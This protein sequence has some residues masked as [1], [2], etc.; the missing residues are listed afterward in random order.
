MNVKSI[1]T[2]SKRAVLLLIMGIAGTMLPVECDKILHGTK[3]ESFVQRASCARQAVLAGD[4]QRAYELMAPVYNHAIGHKKSSG[5]D[6]RAKLNDIIQ[7]KLKGNKSALVEEYG[8]EDVYAAMA[9][10]ADVDPATGRQVAIQEKNRLPQELVQQVQTALQAE[11]VTLPAIRK[12]VQPKRPKAV[13]PAVKTFSP[14]QQRAEIERSRAE[15]ESVEEEVRPVEPIVPAQ[16]PEIERA[17][18]ITQPVVAEPVIEEPVIPQAPPISEYEEERVMYRKPSKPAST[19]GLIPEARE[20]VL[21]SGIMRQPQPVRPTVLSPEPVPE[22][23]K[24]IRTIERES[25]AIKPVIEE[26]PVIPEAPPISAQEEERVMYRKPSKPASTRGLIPGAQEGVLTSG[27]M[28]QPR[29]QTLKEGGEIIHPQQ[30]GLIICLADSEEGSVGAETQRVVACLHD[31]V[32]LLVSA[33]LLKN[34]FV[35]LDITKADEKQLIKKLKEYKEFFPEGQYPLGSHELRLVPVAM[36]RRAFKV[37]DWIIRQIGEGLVLMLPMSVVKRAGGSADVKIGDYTERELRL[38]LKVDS[39]PVLDGDRLQKFLGSY[40]VPESEETEY[41]M[42][43]IWPEENN[44]N[45]FMIRANYTVST[46]ALQPQWTLLLSGHGAL[47]RLIAA[48][49]IGD[50][51]NWLHFMETKI[52]TRF[53]NLESCYSMGMSSRFGF[54]NLD[55]NIEEIDES[56]DAMKRKGKILSFPVALAAAYDVSVQS[57]SMIVTL[58]K[59]DQLE[60]QYEKRFKQFFDYVWDKKYQSEPYDAASIMQTV[61]FLLQPYY[62]SPEFWKN[63]EEA[64]I[65]IILQNYPQILPAGRDTFI[66]LFPGVEIGSVMARTRTEPLDVVAASRQKGVTWNYVFLLLQAQFDEVEQAKPAMERTGKLLVRFPI[67]L[68]KDATQKHAPFIMSSSYG[69]NYYY[70]QKMDSGWPLEDIINSI[71]RLRYGIPKIFWIAEFIDRSSGAPVT[72]KD[73]IVDKGSDLKGQTAAIYVTTPEKTYLHYTYGYELQK[74]EVITQKEF[75]DKYQKL[76]SFALTPSS[77]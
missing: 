60:F 23:P 45:L 48:L 62:Y 31:K 39:N 75:M 4:N 77:K 30:Q 41:F 72:Y 59:E 38:G 55:K 22:E 57:G 52:V 7:I 20:G 19:R 24:E 11:V 14:E 40:K 36:M 42:D 6:S 37:D 21:P 34:I 66:N 61:V 8:V 58:N 17:P 5:R 1:I 67:V 76:F 64:D 71:A 28:I 32:P 73:V 26:E 65:R 70:I 18:I 29:T 46:Q 63:N 9:I 33:S 10:I 56:I 44:S 16:K 74:P 69:T 35:D 43:S 49:P 25:I 3:V 15:R 2:M 50:F 27:I 51:I 54:E 53:F 13:R 47:G 68:R 12:P